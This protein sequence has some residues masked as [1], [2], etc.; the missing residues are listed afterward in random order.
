MIR[1][2][3]FGLGRKG[4][5]ILAMG[6]LFGFSAGGLAQS[7]DEVK[8]TQ[9][10]NPVGWDINIKSQTLAD[11]FLCTQTGPITD[12][13]LWTSLRQG[14]T[15]AAPYN[16][17]LSIWSDAP[18]IPGVS[19]YS[20]PN[21]LLKTWT[22]QPASIEPITTPPEGW[23]DPFNIPT[24]IVP[25]DHVG[26]D[27]YNFL[28]PAGE[29]FSQTE[30]N[31]Y[32]LSVTAIP[33]TEFERSMIGW[34]TS[35]EHWNDDGTAWIGQQWVELRDPSTQQSLDL[36]FELTTKSVP[37]GSTTALLLAISLACIGG[38]RRKLRQQ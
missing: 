10:P 6:L 31:I 23:Y 13:H 3:L 27:K 18:A 30:G 9:P 12:I 33:T 37:D 34:K 1:N 21:A 2:I 32:W 29:E 17:T 24:E 19:A 4:A 11:D 25:G 36:A 26:M 28:I 22:L 5:A 14:V 7:A 35:I 20:H 38:I 16:F 8:L 15:P